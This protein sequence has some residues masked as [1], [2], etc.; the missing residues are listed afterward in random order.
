MEQIW[1]MQEPAYSREEVENFA[2]NMKSYLPLPLASMLANRIG[3][4][5]DKAR[6]FLFPML[7]Q[8]HDPFLYHDMDK[9]VCRIAK[10]IESNERILVYGDYDVDGTTSVALVYSFLKE[11]YNNIDYYIPDRY[12]EGYG[13]SFKGVD[14]AASTGC[15]LIISVDCGIKDNAR[16]EYATYKGID[17]IVCDHHTPGAD[18]PRAVAVL[19]AKRTDNTYPFNELSGCGVA[20]KLMQAYCQYANISEEKLLKYIDLVAVSI[21]SDIVPMRDENRILAYAG[22][23]KLNCEDIEYKGQNLAMS[24]LPPFRAIINEAGLKDIHITVSDSLFLIGP[25]INA[26][27]RM[28]SG[29]EAV[30]LLVCTDIDEA[31][32]YAKEIAHYNDDRKEADREITESA[33]ATLAN[34][35][36]NVKNCSTVVYGDNWHKGVVGIVASRLTETYYR[37]TIVLS[38]KDNM[39]TGSARSVSDFNI[40]DAIDSCRK[41]LTAFGG[42]AFAAGLSMKF[43][44]FN[45]FKHDFEQY[46]CKHVTESQRKPTILID[47]ELKFSELTDTFYDRLQMFQP[48]GPENPEPI[49][50]TYGVYNAGNTRAVGKD[51]PKKHLRF[52]VTDGTVKMITGIGFGFAGFESTIKSGEKV[53]I[54]YTVSRNYYNGVSSIQIMVKDVRKSK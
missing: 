45:N 38:K 24:P 9:A 46:V 10:A 25:R 13:V 20:F 48:F 2:A 14:Y 4:D 19:D 11:F 43:E 5:I 32:R 15:G 27:G 3:I 49:F 52:E 26:A 29:R 34:D 30:N 12:T 16:I 28:K 54:C 40:Y 8:L 39:L 7:K 53:D 37:P 33:L 41:Y 23:R 50:V 31:T 18:L 17:F 36:D 51:E 6:N 21:I 44:D 47:Q 35:P 22:L 1:K 42:H